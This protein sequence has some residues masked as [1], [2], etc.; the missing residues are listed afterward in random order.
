MPNL[1]P[2][3]TNNQL[4]RNA[5]GKSAVLVRAILEVLLI[6][7]TV[8]T[9]L[10]LNGM[11]AEIIRIINSVMSDSGTTLPE[12]V[13]LSSLIPSMIATAIPMIL[14]A[15]AYFI[16]YGK[17]RSSSPNA[18]SDTGFIILNIFAILKLIGTVIISGIGIAAGVIILIKQPESFKNNK[19]IGIVVPIAVIAVFV[20]ILIFAIVYKMY[21]GSVRKTAK[22]A[23]LC[24]SGAKAY[25]VFS[26]LFAIISFFNVLLSL[27]LVLLHKKLYDMVRDLVSS[28]ASEQIGSFLS[29]SGSWFYLTL[30]FS[31]LVTFVIYIVDAKIALGYNNCI[32]EARYRG[33]GNPPAN[34]GFYSSDTQPAAE[35]KKRGYGD[36]FIED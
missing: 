8:G 2:V 9:Y 1:N 23:E 26:I 33:A 32:K 13:L 35:R 25:G 19:A 20:F 30:L 27:G 22:T 3:Q 12:N 4:L 24:N 14:T 28:A 34:D 31:A 16:I 6:A 11:F 5:F 7:A 10:T 17:S 18:R 29:N 36:R 15:A 21:I